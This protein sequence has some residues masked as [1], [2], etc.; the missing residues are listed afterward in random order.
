MATMIIKFLAIL[1]LVPAALYGT[2][3]ICVMLLI[4]LKGIKK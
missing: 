3:V 4:F 2:F 1:A